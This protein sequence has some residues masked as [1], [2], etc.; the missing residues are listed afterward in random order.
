M[1]EAFRWWLSLRRNA[2]FWDWMKDSYG[3]EELRG[4][5]EEATDCKLSE[6]YDPF[7]ELT[8]DQQM[9]A[10][11]HRRNATKRLYRRYGGDIWHACLAALNEDRDSNVFS[12]L[13]RLEL[14][15]QVSSPISF[16]EFLVRNAMKC[17]ARQI[18]ENRAISV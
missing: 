17:A 10:D 16:E 12:C 4:L 3:A 7:G 5:T 11:S 2:N 9:I 6:P 18:L 13:S 15:N 1:I 14:A 8:L